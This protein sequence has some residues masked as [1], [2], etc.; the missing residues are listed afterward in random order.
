MLVSNNRKLYFFSRNDRENSNET[1]EID[2]L[3]SDNNITSKHNIIPIE[4]KS[5]ERYTFSSI[6]KLKAKYSD[7]LAKPIIIHTKDLKNDENILYLP[8]YMTELL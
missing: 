5:G 6:S 3:I 8:V 7:Y 4:V 2:F 1:M